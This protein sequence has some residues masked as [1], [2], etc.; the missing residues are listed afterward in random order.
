MFEKHIVF[1]LAS[2]YLISKEAEYIFINLQAIFHLFIWEWPIYGLGLWFYRFFSS[3][4]H[5]SF[6]QKKYY[7][8][9]YIATIFYSQ[10]LIMMKHF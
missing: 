2:M 6:L 7:F 8:V 3:L 1:A 9:T 5:L 4:S 10:I